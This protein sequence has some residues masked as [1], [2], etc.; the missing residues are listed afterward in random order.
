MAY[1]ESFGYLSTDI[2]VRNLNERQWRWI[3]FA[4]D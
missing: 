3:L 4:F 1:Q 2:A